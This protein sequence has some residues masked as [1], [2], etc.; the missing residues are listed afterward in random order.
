M[1]M[2]PTLAVIFFPITIMLI[3]LFAIGTCLVVFGMIL[4]TGVDSFMMK[5]KEVS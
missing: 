5:N 2:I 4:Y 1:K 3:I